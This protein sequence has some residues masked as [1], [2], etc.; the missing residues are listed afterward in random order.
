MLNIKCREA[1]QAYGK[2][3]TGVLRIIDPLSGGSARTRDQSDLRKMHIHFGII[4]TTEAMAATRTLP[5]LPQSRRGGVYASPARLRQY[6]T[7]E[8]ITPQPPLV[9]PIEHL[10]KWDNCNVEQ[11]GEHFC[12]PAILSCDLADDTFFFH[13]QFSARCT[14]LW[15]LL[16]K[17]FLLQP[18]RGIIFQDT[19]FADGK[20][21]T[22]MEMPDCGNRQTTKRSAT[23]KQMH[24][25]TGLTV[26]A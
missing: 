4:N 21:C 9:K 12:V 6:F 1:A 3:A 18:P 16:Q 8:R 13:D 10:K 14:D 2:S 11:K 25:A 19:M 23:A 24:E 17:E 26:H 15:R 7:Y 22:L 5:P 20:K